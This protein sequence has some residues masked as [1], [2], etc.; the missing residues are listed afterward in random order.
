MSAHIT[1]NISAVDNFFNYRYFFVKQF[2]TGAI[3]FSN[4]CIIQFCNPSFLLS[5]LFNQ[6][7]SY[8]I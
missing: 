8:I 2:G 1:I 5:L 6:L 3:L 4:E 7:K